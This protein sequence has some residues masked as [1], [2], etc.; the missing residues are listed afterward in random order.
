MPTTVELPFGFVADLSFWGT[1]LELPSFELG[2]VVFAIIGWAILALILFF[3]GAELWASLRQTKYTSDWKWTVL[4]VDVPPDTIQSPKAVEQIFAIISGAHSGSSVADKYGP[5]FKQRWFSLEVI[6]LEGYIQFLVYTE[7]KFR[8]LVEAAVYAQYPMAEITEV[9]DYVSVIPNTYP[10][11]THDVVGIEFGLATEDAYPIRTYSDFEHS[12]TPD[13]TFNDPMAAILENFTRIGAGENL[14]LQIIVEPISSKWKEHGIGLVKNSLHE[15][16]N[17]LVK[18]LIENKKHEVK[19]NFLLKILNSVATDILHNIASPGEAVVK[20]K[21]E[22][23]APGKVSDLSPGMRDTI[24]AIE[25]KIS[26]IGFKAKIRVMYAAEKEAFKPSRC[27]EGL[28]G[29]IN[30]FSYPGRNAIV[31]VLS[32]KN[33]KGKNQFVS[34]FKKRKIKIGK[35]PFILNIEELATLWH[36]PLPLVKAP[37]LQKT[38]S[39]R[40]E[41]PINLP[42]EEVVESPLR[43]KVKEEPVEAALPEEENTPG[44]GQPPADLPYA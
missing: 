26:K 24:V 42:I 38:A 20:K 12:V 32:P 1:I 2:K 31:P 39:K 9:E 15:K 25:E 16:G 21:E 18:S 6:S 22:K 7:E 37:L 30:Q 35:N 5:G 44:L 40:A 11:K 4:A 36:F 29:A 43:K 23:A 14:W 13:F 17:K 28:I 3:M 10:N 41:P 27:L 19:Q 34:A 33:D 8:D